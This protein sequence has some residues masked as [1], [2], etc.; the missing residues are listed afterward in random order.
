MHHIWPLRY[1]LA[2]PGKSFWKRFCF[3]DKKGH[4]QLEYSFA[5]PSYLCLACGQQLSCN[6]EVTNLKIRANM[7]C[8][9][10]GWQTRK[11]KR[12]DTPGGTFELLHRLCPANLWTSCCVRQT[13][14]STMVGFSTT[15]AERILQGYPKDAQ[16]HD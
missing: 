2:S 14:L 12:A 4:C 9:C 1:K 10:Y 3:P 8:C 13:H 11:I 6:Q 16:D 15:A 7:L 5:P